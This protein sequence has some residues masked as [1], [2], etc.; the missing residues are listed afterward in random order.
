M[1]KDYQLP[2]SV[3][4]KFFLFLA[5]WSPAFENWSAPF[6]SASFTEVI[7]PSQSSF[8]PRISQHTHTRTRTHMHRAYNEKFWQIHRIICPLTLFHIEQFHH[9]KIPLMC[10]FVDHHYPLPNLAVSILLIFL[11]VYWGVYRQIVK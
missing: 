11:Q 9:P 8:H 10:P 2:Y 7:F 4:I 1:R 5:S 3:Y 6:L